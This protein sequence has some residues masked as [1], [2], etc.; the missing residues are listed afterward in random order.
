MNNFRIGFLKTLSLTLPFLILYLLLF[1][2]GE[3][4]LQAHRSSK[5]FT[6]HD[7]KDFEFVVSTELH[8]IPETLRAYEERLNWF[9]QEFRLK[10]KDL[11]HLVPMTNRIPI[12][13]CKNHEELM[14][15]GW[16]TLR[17]DLTNNGGF[18]DPL[19]RRIA[20]VSRRGVEA[21]EDSLF[22]EMTHAILDLGTTGDPQW[23][24]W[25]NEGLAQYFE[26]SV[27]N[28]KLGQLD[29]PSV[30]IVKTMVDNEARFIPLARLIES[31]ESPFT[32][33]ENAFYY[34]ESHLLVTYLMTTHAPQFSLYI[35]EERRPGRALPSMLERCFGPLGAL[36][37]EFKEYVRNLPDKGF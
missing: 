2:F 32:S 1:V 11:F 8:F 20:I 4:L 15:H 35:V 36:E 33:D 16:E 30:H 9:T 25:L 34:A 21:D 7:L 12:W 18:Y 22:H 3:S 6:T 14:Q 19:N 37:R 28:Q 5:G 31:S 29:S 10:Y 17:Q 26:G 24:A 23:S 13:F 27:Y